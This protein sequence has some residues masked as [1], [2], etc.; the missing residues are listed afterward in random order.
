MEY[1]YFLPFRHDRLFLLC[2]T[3]KQQKMKQANRKKRRPSRIFARKEQ[4]KSKKTF[5][6]KN[7]LKL[8]QST[9][10][11]KHQF[12]CSDISLVILDTRNN[13]NNL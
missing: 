8:Q 13:R 2:T 1:F 6:R 5:I 9:D 12:V 4:K 10:M 11:R 7:V 3:E